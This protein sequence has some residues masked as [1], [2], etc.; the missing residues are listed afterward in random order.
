MKHVN[1][2][3]SGKGIAGQGSRKTLKTTLV[4]CTWHAAKLFSLAAGRSASARLAVRRS[5]AAASHWPPHSAAP[6]SNCRT[7]ARPK[8]PSLK[9]GD[10]SWLTAQEPAWSR[11]NVW[12]GIC[13]IHKSYILW[14]CWS[15]KLADF[16]DSGYTSDRIPFIVWNMPQWQSASLVRTL[17]KTLNGNNIDMNR[18]D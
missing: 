17:E 8:Y 18:T 5:L 13:C 3:T 11:S 12:E 1:V 4:T 15:F 14:Y 2:I 16:A 9:H 7:S 10:M 6:I